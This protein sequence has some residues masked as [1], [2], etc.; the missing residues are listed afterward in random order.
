MVGTGVIVAIS[1][2]CMRTPPDAVRDASVM[3]KNCLEVL[4]I[5]I[6]GAERKTSLSLMKASSRSFVQEKA[7]PFLVKSWRGRASAEKF[8]MNFR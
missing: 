4:G 2:F 6:T 3:T 5:Q 7:T 8:R 1:I